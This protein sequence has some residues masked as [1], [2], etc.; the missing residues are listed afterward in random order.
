MM[1]MA[2]G[3]VVAVALL[4]LV[5]CAQIVMSPLMGV[6]YTEVSGPITATSSERG[7]KVGVA[8]A[9]SILG[10]I[11]TGDASI[12]AAARNG[13][14]MQIRTVDYDSTNILGLYATFTTRV[15]GD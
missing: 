5:G 7:S 6:A 9:T 1:R 11:A 10:L 12:A 4:G 3:M 15:T 13:G 14:I 8:E 2:K